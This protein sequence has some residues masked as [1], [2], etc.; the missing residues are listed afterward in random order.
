MSFILDLNNNH[1]SKKISYQVLL[2]KI[3]FIQT[4]II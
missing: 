2:T 3:R 1:L 4:Q